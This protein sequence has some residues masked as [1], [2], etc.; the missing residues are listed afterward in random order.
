MS[1]YASKIRSRLESENKTFTS[2]EIDEE[3]KKLGVL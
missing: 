2:T 3:M 1:F